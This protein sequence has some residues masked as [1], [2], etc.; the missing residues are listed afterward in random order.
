MPVCARGASLS[1]GYRLF[2]TEQFMKDMRAIAR[3][4]LTRIEQKLRKIVYPELKQQPHFGPHIK[5]LKGWNPETWRYRI[6]AWRF[7]YVIDEE[8]HIV[9]MTAA[10]HRGS[11]Y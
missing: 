2:E 9:F 11:A 6:G 10:E 1:N 3:S 4:G 5:K 7:F 8:A